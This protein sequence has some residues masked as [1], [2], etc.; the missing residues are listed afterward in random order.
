MLA[1]SATKLPPIISDRKRFDLAS[2][3]CKAAPLSWATSAVDGPLMV[4]Y[5]AVAR[6]SY[7]PRLFGLVKRP[8]QKYRG[9]DARESD[10][11]QRAYWQPGLPPD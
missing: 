9:T 11:I 6:S 1:G 8:I 3:S 2:L 10:R 5:C 7:A 4:D